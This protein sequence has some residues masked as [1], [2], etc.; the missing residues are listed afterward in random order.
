MTT[1]LGEDI[2][3]GSGEPLSGEEGEYVEETKDPGVPGVT[4]E[5]VDTTEEKSKEE[6]PKKAEIIKMR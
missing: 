1:A 2:G 6:I 3:Y 4:A 5:N